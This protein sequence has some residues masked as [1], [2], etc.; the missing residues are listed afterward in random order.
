VIDS[1]G[2]PVTGLTPSDFTI[3]ENGIRQII[4]VFEAHTLTPEPQQ[5]SPATRL[6]PLTRGL[7]AATAAAPNQRVFLFVF[8]RGRLQAPSRGVDAVIDFVAHRLLPQDRVAVMAWNRATDFTTSR[9]G[10]LT[11]LQ[12]IKTQ[13]EQIELE[14]VDF[15]SGLRAVYGSKDIPTYIQTR[16][17]AVF[18]APGAERTHVLPSGT[19]TDSR[20][21]AEDLRRNVDNVVRSELNKVPPPEGAP[22]LL[23]SAY[24]DPLVSMLGVGFDEF[25][26]KSS[27]AGQQ[28]GQLFAAIRYLRNFDGEKHVVFVNEAGIF[29]PRLE[30]DESIAAFANDARVVIDTIRTG[31]VMVM[32]PLVQPC[33]GCPTTVD[34]NRLGRVSPMLMFA[35][36]TTRNIAD[37][38]G[39]M[40]GTVRPPSELLSEIDRSTRSGY[41][42]GY[43]PSNDA[44]D[45]KYRRI[46]VKVNRR[47][48]RVLYRH[49][50][51]ASEALRPL[52]P[53]VF[54]TYARMA[55]AGD[56]VEPIVDLPVSATAEFQR[57]ARGIVVILTVRIDRVGLDTADGRR[58]GA[59]Q[60]ATFCGDENQAV[61]G[62][63]WQ[64]AHLNLSDATYR[65]ILAEGLTVT[66]Q[67]E[68]T[69]PPKFV[70]VIAYDYGSDLLGSAIVIV[71]VQ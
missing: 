36:Q 59:I 29:L 8:G 37:M 3:E 69:R 26:A 61:V 44:L 4:R 53:K 57:G 45:G 14:L 17:D 22:R 5:A 64:T 42:I 39:G 49:G 12:H 33:A 62:E 54:L 16:I 50:Y 23:S 6:P 9:R 58:T 10:I 32:N 51:Y 38:T 27:E 52:D 24:E 35:N 1:A 34:P 65:R 7:T 21:Q 47:H 63:V 71:S 41:L 25:V 31:G 68:V 46:V 20:Q 2:K 56:T 28:V 66:Q 19:P 15:F 48:V 30:N 70:K 67:I 55:E 11:T 40:S 13:H 43:A 60:I 18:E